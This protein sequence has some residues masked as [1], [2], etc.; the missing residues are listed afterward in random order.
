MIYSRKV[1]KCFGADSDQEMGDHLHQQ[2][3]KWQEV[4]IGWEV[5]SGQE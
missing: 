5:I 1:D 3:C 4:E 2:V